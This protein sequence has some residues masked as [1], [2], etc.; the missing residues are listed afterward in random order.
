M[1]EVGIPSNYSVGVEE[2]FLIVDRDS[3]A[4]TPRGPELIESSSSLGEHVCA[5]LNLCQI[6]VDTPVCTDLAEVGYQ[7]AAETVTPYAGQ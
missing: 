1:S 3:R 5:E 7:V 6:E 2:E 4:L